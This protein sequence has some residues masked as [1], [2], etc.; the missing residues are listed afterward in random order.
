MSSGILFG[1]TSEVCTQILVPKICD[2]LPSTAT[3]RKQSYE[4][5][6]LVML[7]SDEVT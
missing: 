7:L 4:I 3:G 1:G 5:R 6:S 2:V